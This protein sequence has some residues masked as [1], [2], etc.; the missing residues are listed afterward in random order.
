ME[1]DIAKAVKSYLESLQQKGELPENMADLDEGGLYWAIWEV[2]KNYY[3]NRKPYD[4]ATG[5]GF[6][7]VN[8]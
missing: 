4:P 3:I 6:K 2:T 5:N 1:N 7:S 8:I